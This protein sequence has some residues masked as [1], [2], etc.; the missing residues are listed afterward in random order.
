MKKYE[1]PKM[2]VELFETEDIITASSSP[3]NPIQDEGDTVSLG[4]QAPW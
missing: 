4:E 2:D 3:D 1:T